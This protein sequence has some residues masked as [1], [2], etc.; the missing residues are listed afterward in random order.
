MIY[1]QIRGKTMKNTS[2]NRA[3]D[4]KLA[5]EE[6]AITNCD[7]IATGKKVETYL[8]LLYQAYLRGETRLEPNLQMAVWRK[9]KLHADFPTKIRLAQLQCLEISSDDIDAPWDIAKEKLFPEKDINFNV[10][11]PKEQENIIKGYKE[12]IKTLL[13]TN[14]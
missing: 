13:I 2:K 3:V 9:V 10:V 14:S 1:R 5:S 8:L 6:L 7:K 11:V 4:L 12:K